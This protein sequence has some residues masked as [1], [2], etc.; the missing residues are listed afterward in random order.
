[1][2]RQNRNEL[3]FQFWGWILFVACAVF[4]IASGIRNN[5]GLTIVGSV[6]FLTACILF[7]IPI[8]KARW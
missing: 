8:I 6:I 3:R 1:M 2:N 4:F 7:L 5:D